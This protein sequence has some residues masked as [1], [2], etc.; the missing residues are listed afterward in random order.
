[1]PSQKNINI[2]SSLSLHKTKG[3]ISS[4]YWDENYIYIMINIKN[5]FAEVKSYG[6]IG[7]EYIDMANKRF[8]D[9]ESERNILELDS[10]KFSKS[11][12]IFISK[13][14]LL[15]LNF[16]TISIVLSFEASSATNIS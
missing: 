6:C 11:A 8:S 9:Y 3:S 1:M 10:K 13:S 2:V 5:N 15:F 7:F 4:K 12:Y 16:S 14:G